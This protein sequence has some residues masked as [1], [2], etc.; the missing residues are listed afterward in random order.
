MKH[1]LFLIALSIVLV[2]CGGSSSNSKMVNGKNFQEQCDQTIEQCNRLQKA[3]SELSSNASVER[4]DEVQQLSDELAFNY[5][6]SSLDSMQLVKAKEVDQLIAEAKQSI[7]L[8]LDQTVKQGL[9]NTFVSSQPL[10][11]LLF[12]FIFY[13]QNFLWQKI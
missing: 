11:P 3:V 13:F 9:W 8:Q 5:D 4:I 2:A 1:S 10:M 6:A 7:A 12:L